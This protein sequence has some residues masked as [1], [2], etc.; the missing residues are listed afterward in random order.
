MSKMENVSIDSGDIKI[1]VVVPVYN[2]AEYIK[3]TLDSIFKQTLKPFEVVMVDDGSVDESVPII[4]DYFDS[5]KHIISR[6]KIIKQKNM[7]AGAARN[8]GIENATGNWIAFLDSDDIWDSDKIYLT[9][10]AIRENPKAMMVSHDMYVVTTGDF[11]SKKYAALHERYDKTK[12]LFS[13]LYRR[14]FLPTPCVTIKKGFLENVGMF[15]TT[16][17]SCQD[18][19]LWLKCSLWMNDVDNL[20]IINK[21]LF[22]YLIREGS[23]SYNTKKRYECGKEVL[24]RYRPALG[25]YMEKGKARNFARQAMNIFVFGE[26]YS[27]LKKRRIVKALELMLWYMHDFVMGIV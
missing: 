14:P 10:R 5:N 12:P 22:Y 27:A 25:R 18:W 4:E 20:V 8:I 3:R 6:T 13:Q 15:D 24:M 1:S 17:P 23:I 19:D 26:V 7:G 16:L 11:K 2:G 21:A 9:V